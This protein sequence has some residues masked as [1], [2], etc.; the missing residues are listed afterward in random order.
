MP[1]PYYK[2]ELGTLYHGD[3]LEI[4]PHLGPVDLV[5]TDPPYGVAH[6][7]GGDKGT[8][9]K[10]VYGTT[11]FDDT[12]EYRK[13]VV[14][15]FI[16]LCVEK[17]ERVVL[18]PGIFG[19][20]DYPP[21]D[22]IGCFWTPAAQ[23]HGRWGFRTFNPILYYGKSPR[24]GKGDSP[25]GKQLTEKAKKNGHPCPKPIGAWMWLLHKASFSTD[26]VLD[27]FIG[28]GTTA[29]AC[30]RLNRRWIGIEISEKYCEIAAKQIEDE[31][32]Q[33]KLFDRHITHNGL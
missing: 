13:N 29:V 30:E 7:T 20:R 2:T 16:A 1:R 19:L 14:V 11:R 27:P 24:A 28:S 25:S 12:E 31:A 9:Q 3:C 18:T 10:A 5:L 32:R 26:T 6:C 23:T 22:D 17:F 8:Y 21:P 33:L 15:P 4:M